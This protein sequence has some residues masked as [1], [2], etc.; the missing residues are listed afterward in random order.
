MQQPLLLNVVSLIAAQD[1]TQQNV[2][3]LVLLLVITLAVA[4][5]S[6]PLR[7]PYTLVLVVV[8]L[9]IGVS[10]LL[11]NVSL[12]PNVVLFLFLPA[13]LF[14]GAWNVDVQQ[15]IADWPVVLLLS[16][17]G[18]L[19]SVLVV[20]ALLHWTLGLPWLLVLLLGAMISPTDP[21][22]VLALLRQMGL[23]DR[24]RT[25]VEGESLFNDGVGAAVFE[26][27]LGLLL[28][29]L[30]GTVHASS[31]WL[32][33]LQALW[34]MSGGLLL[35]IGVGLVVARLLRLVDDHLIE[36]TV[37]VSV[38]YGVYL[39]GVVLHTSGL[40]AVVGAGLI[41]GSYGRRT[42]L[43]ERALQASHDVWEF[44]GY[45]ANSLLF[46]FL[47]IQIGESHLLQSL[48]AIGLA[49]IGV[50]IGRAAMI[51][52]LVPLHDAFSRRLAHNKTGSSLFSQLQPL[53]R[54]WRPVI[55]LS[56]LRGALSVALVLSL[57]ATLPERG[58]LEAIVYGVVLVTLLGQGI[59][60][61]ILL[62]RWGK[63]ETGL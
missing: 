6:R 52:L 21:I 10:P 25:I 14:E 17:P 15:L 49:L 13:L 36:M 50:I 31:F 33:A 53:P 39:L 60:L 54:R 57:P 59:G 3:L 11:P 56:G 18:L 40:L 63:G 22:A 62:P 38:A 55:L 20:A 9:I 43:S 23:S 61:R 35:G 24:L 7:L 32:L 42:G 58:L 45:L 34:L 1:A 19:L 47:G 51:Y 44:L 28:V 2:Q 37:T 48:V 29:S 5:I 41:M 4:L 30:G 16:V 26:L 46:L 27:V 8:G 12:N